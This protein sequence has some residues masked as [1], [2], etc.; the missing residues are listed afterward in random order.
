MIH[1]VSGPRMA[2]L[3]HN[4]REGS[5]CDPNLQCNNNNNITLI[6][7]ADQ[8]RPRRCS[9]GLGLSRTRIPMK[10]QSLTSLAQVQCSR[11]NINSGTA[12]TCAALP[13]HANDG[14]VKLST[15]RL[16]PQITCELYEHQR[17][18]TTIT[19]RRNTYC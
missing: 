17:K 3:R 1:M 2:N 6:N 7:L 4:L 9:P 19:E 18:T 5:F 13:R 16:C 14:V 10:P 12:L 8:T 11:C 15:L